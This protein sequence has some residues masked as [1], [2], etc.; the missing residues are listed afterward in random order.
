MPHEDQHQ[1]PLPPE[2]AQAFLLAVRKGHGDIRCLAGFTRHGRF[3]LQEK[4]VLERWR[5]IPPWSDGVL[6]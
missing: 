4:G 2:I 3:L 1:L 6:E 5:I